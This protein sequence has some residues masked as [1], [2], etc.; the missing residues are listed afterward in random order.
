[1]FHVGT[2]GSLDIAQDKAQTLGG[3]EIALRKTIKG[4]FISSRIIMIRLFGEA[5]SK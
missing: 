5:T 3:G 1:M 4:G 2:I